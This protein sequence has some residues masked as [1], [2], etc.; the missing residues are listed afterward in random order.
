[1]EKKSEFMYMRYLDFDTDFFEKPSFMIDLEK[2]HFTP[3]VEIENEFK[4]YFQ[5]SF[6][7]MKATQTV[8]HELLIFLQECGLYFVDT[9]IK[10]KCKKPKAVRNGLEVLVIDDIK[11]LDIDAFDSVFGH[12]RFHIDTHIPKDKADEQW[13]RYLENFTV[14]DNHKIYLAIVDGRQAAYIS[15]HI[16]QEEAYLFSVAVSEAFRG[17]GV[18]SDLI[19][20][21]LSELVSQGFTVFTGTYARNIQAVKFYMKNGFDIEEFK[22]VYH[23]Y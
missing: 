14:D 5:D 12:S 20:S 17:Q 4:K 19:Q 2:S 10:L 3:K 8:K 9:E 1:M 21:V 23:K 11:E 15:A 13:R 7:S 6:I 16:D 18:G 22:Y